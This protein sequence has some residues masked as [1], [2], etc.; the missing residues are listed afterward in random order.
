MADKKEYPEHIRQAVDLIAA[1]LLML[2]TI[3]PP[4][5]YFI[6]PRLYMST[7]HITICEILHQ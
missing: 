4:L 6:K 3:S 2:S 1:I 7:A 5:S